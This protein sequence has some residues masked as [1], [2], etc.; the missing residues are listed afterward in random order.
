MQTLLCQPRR[1]SWVWTSA[2]LVALVVCSC[3]LLL[4]STASATN[5]TWKGGGSST[6]WSNAGNWL[7][8]T[9]PAASASIGTLTFPLL[10]G[11]DSE[12]DLSGLSVNH[13]QVDDSHDYV[14]TGQGLTLGSGG[15]SIG[16]SE[17]TA[18]SFITSTPLTLSGNQTWS[19]SQ[20][21]ILG[22]DLSGENS[23]LTMNVNGVAQFS[24]GDPYPGSPFGPLSVNDELGNVTIN[25]SAPGAS[26]VELTGGTFNADDGHMLSLHNVQLEG[27]AVT[28]PITAS[29]SNLFLGGGSATGPVTLTGS[30]LSVNERLSLPSLSLDEHSTFMSYIVAQGNT[31]GTDYDQIT[32]T[33]TVGLGGATLEPIGVGTNNGTECPS[34]IVGQVDTLVSTTGSLTGTFGNAPNGG[35][36][37]TVCV[38]AARWYSYRIN[39]N[40][41]SSP[42]TVT[43]TALPAV[44][45]FGEPPT[46]SGT[47]TEGQTLTE[48]HGYWTNNPTSYSEEWQ[49]CN[50]G[51]TACQPISGATAQNY[52]VTAT[53]VGSTIRVQETATNSEG[54]STPTFSEPTG[55]V[56][57]APAGGS[58]GGGSTT[59][60]GGSTGSS[61]GST[62]GGDTTATISSAQIA[63]LLG[64]QLVPSGKSAKIAALLKNDG[65]TMS[66]KAL[67]A[68]T[69]S[70]Q[71]YEVPSGAKLAKKT[72]AKPVLVASG[73]MAFSAAGM[74]QVKVRLTA[75]GKRLLKHAKRVKLTA[76][77]V[78][79]ARGGAAVTVMKSV[80]LTG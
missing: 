52:T 42:E 65:L 57:A 54:A 67:E 38:P 76:K 6:A 35:T 28:G 12:N 41:S 55:I 45:T 59:S 58:G 9:A 49:R 32:S 19:V 5:Y 27:G 70:V 18:G 74:G 34:P 75:V 61:T 80:S 79:T 2:A 11:Q 64:Q 13:L 16:A 24:F 22:G 4:A 20:H 25:G 7:G 43:A 46:I 17:G 56:Q 71:W 26:V 10:S 53:D 47:A 29:D 3:S 73:Q 63:A 72:K 60:G 44:P 39:Y 36:I 62:S 1:Q 48:T 40:T 15:L 30:Q 31:P 51:G 14:L 68:G 78:F 37:V 33:G 69:L 21:V 77:G 50:S 8:G 66:F 23:D